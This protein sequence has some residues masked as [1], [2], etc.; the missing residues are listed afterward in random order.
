MTNPV[1]KEYFYE[2][3]M[4]MMGVSDVDAASVD[5]SDV[6]EKKAILKKMEK[7]LVS[8]YEFKLLILTFF[9]WTILIV[10]TQSMGSKDW[11]TVIVF[12][13]IGLLI[14]LFNRFYF[15]R[16]ISDFRRYRHHTHNLEDAYGVAI[17]FKKRKINVERLSFILLGCMGAVVIVLQ[18]AQLLPQWLVI[19][20]LADFIF[21]SIFL[22]FRL[23]K[24]LNKLTT[25][26]SH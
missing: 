14:L 6:S 3:L 2:K 1:V 18:I 8:R 13:L 20:L 23:K 21:F 22:Y 10:I 24:N 16:E 4:K 7:M 11:I 15:S 25:V 9:I 5:S 26:K 17:N 19:F 12:G